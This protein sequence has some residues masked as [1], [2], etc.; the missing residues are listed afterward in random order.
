MEQCDP[1]HDHEVCLYF[2]KV[3][4]TMSGTVPY[5]VYMFVAIITLITV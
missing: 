2:G 1:L 4:D 3:L 5:N